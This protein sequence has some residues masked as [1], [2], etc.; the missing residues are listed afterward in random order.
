ASNTVATRRLSGSTWR[1]AALCQI[2]FILRAFDLQMAQ[3][4]R[5]CRALDEFVLH[6]QRQRQ[7]C[8]GHSL[9]QKRP[10]RP[11]QVRAWNTLTGSL[12]PLNTF[13]LTEII[14]DD[15][16]P[17]ALVVAHTHAFSTLA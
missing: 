16:L 12:P 5:F 10:N 15:A 2:G 4:L 6:S 8:W 17:P 7:G 11:I 14:G 9:H 1:L 13:A 3:A